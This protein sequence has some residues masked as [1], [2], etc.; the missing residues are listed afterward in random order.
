MKSEQKRLL[1]EVAS[2]REQ[3]EN[4]PPGKLLCA[5]NGQRYKWYQSDGHHHE[6]IPKSNRKLAEQLAMKKLLSLKEKQLTKEENAVS[7]YLRHHQEEYGPAEQLLSEPAYAELLTS[8]FSPKNTD[9]SEWMNS[10]YDRN[11]NYPEQLIHKTTSGIYVRSKSEATI[12]MY[13]HMNQI[14]FRYE[15]R[16]DL[17]GVTL[18]PDFTIRHPHTG[19]LFYWEHFGLADNRGYRQNMMS[20]LELYMEYGIFPSINLLTTYETREHPLG[21]DT[22]DNMVKFYFG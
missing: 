7:Y 10:A 14:P 16:L 9:L 12:A 19:E 20:K 2:V 8:Y 5:R 3:L 1:D 11:P 21:Y 4:L 15:C 6:Y 17:G 13:L 22:V 18:Y